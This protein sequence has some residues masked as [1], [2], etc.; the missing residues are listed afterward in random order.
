MFGYNDLMEPF[1]N[2]INIDTA[3]QISQNIKRHY[4]EFN[5]TLFH[6]NINSE[7][8]DLELKDRIRFLAK[9][10]HLFLPTDFKISAKILKKAVG[11]HS[12]LSGFNV[13][14]LTEYISNYGE[15]E[16]DLSLEVLKEMTKVFTSEFAVRAFFIKNPNRTLKI[17]KHWAQ[18][19]NEHVRRLV[20]EG[21]RPLLP[22]G[23]K[24][25]EFV[26]SPK[27]T[28]ELLELLK[29]DESLY[30]RKSV[31][32]HLNDHSKN[33]P[34]LV[35]KTLQSWKKSDPKNK[36]I[37]WIIRHASRTLVKKAHP[38]AL[39]LHGVSSKKINVLSLKLKKNQIKINESL[40]IS[41][42]IQNKSKAKSLVILDVD[43][44]LLKANNSHN[45]KCFKGKKVSLD[46]EEKILV[47]LKVPLKK[48]TTR[49][50]YSGVQYLSCK[51]NG[52]ST[53]KK[54]F[55]L[56]C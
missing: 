11:D 20:S 53:P 37:E 21:S 28:I 50:Y 1:K 5:D 7:L 23:Q 47:I 39:E 27:L 44:H 56:D 32:N 26:N 45:I 3:R 2:K 38:K 51:I 6:K 52:I 15:D 12:T 19:E 30:V 25:S 4:P 35:V 22:W 8:T 49:T 41:V 31:A 33:H 13:W 34:D 42:T 17:F 18:D 36:N 14:P 40:E 46:A 43:L 55:K 9:K 24:I 16:L 29:N 10:L 48:V 54:S